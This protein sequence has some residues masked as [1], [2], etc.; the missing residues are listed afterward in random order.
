[1]ANTRPNATTFT[2]VY[3][4]T[5]CMW[6]VIII[7]SFYIV[8]YL[9]VNHLQQLDDVASTEDFMGG[10]KFEGFSRREVGG[11]NTF[12]GA[13]AAENFAG[14]TRAG[15]NRRRR[16]RRWCKGWSR[17]WWRQRR[18]CF[19]C[20]VTDLHCGD[21][22]SK[23]KIYGGRQ[24]TELDFAFFFSFPQRAQWPLIC[25]IGS[26]KAHE[27]L[28]MPSWYWRLTSAYFLFFIFCW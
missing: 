14:C 20:C 16:R 1:M 13:S 22:H 19:S 28:Q 17:R 21:R 26:G 23:S 6:N 4:P 7:T 18:G 27:V 12:V 11:K 10:C 2:I 24:R 25:Y 15:Y 5:R 3:H 9:G 8:N